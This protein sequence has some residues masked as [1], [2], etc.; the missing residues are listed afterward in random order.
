[1]RDVIAGTTRLLSINRNGTQAGLGAS[2]GPVITPDGRHIAFTGTAV[3]AL[4]DDFSRDGRYL[5]TW[6]LDYYPQGQSQIFLMRR[7]LNSGIEERIWLGPNR[8]RDLVELTLDD[9]GRFVALSTSLGLV[10][11]DTNERSD[12]YLLEV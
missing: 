12:V 11:A 9:A 4:D 3:A 6:L 7:E 5:V 2:L 10:P 1:M 8:S